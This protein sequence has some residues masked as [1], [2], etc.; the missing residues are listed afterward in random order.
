MY[1]H[2][3]SEKCAK[4]PE[5]KPGPQK[6]DHSM[7]VYQRL[8]G[9]SLIQVTLLWQCGGVSVK[10]RPWTNILQ[11]AGVS[12]STGRLCVCCMLL[13]PHPPV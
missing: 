9:S 6:S 8:P 2:C 10:C 11:S 7:T 12:N 5:F 4:L 13:A 1:I 3:V